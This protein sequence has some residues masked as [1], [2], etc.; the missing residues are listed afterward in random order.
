MYSPSTVRAFDSD[1]NLLEERRVSDSHEQQDVM[2]EF[3]VKYPGCM[4]ETE[5]DLF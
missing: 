4:I 1:R 5:E 3:A 2:R